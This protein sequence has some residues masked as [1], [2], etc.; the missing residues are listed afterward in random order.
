MINMSVTFHLLIE[1]II[2]DE[3]GSRSATFEK[4]ILIL[5]TF[6]VLSFL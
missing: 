3:N 4:L 1:W 6:A 5:L 2:C